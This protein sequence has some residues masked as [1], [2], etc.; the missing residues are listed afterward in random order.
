[1]D[2]TM[3]TDLA[4]F[5]TLVALSNAVDDHGLESPSLRVIARYAHCSASSLLNW[6]GDKGQLHRRTLIALG[7]TWRFTLMAELLP[8]DE[9]GQVYARLRLA[10]AEIARTDPLV[11]AVVDDLI[12]VERRII[13]DTLR[14]SHR[15]QTI[16]PRIITVLHALL[17]QLWDTRSHP[18]AA[19]SRTLLAEVV[20]ALIGSPRS[21]RAA[22]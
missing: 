22:G 19:A 15:L 7:V 18:D 2:F 13:E 8:A 3:A 17:V 12:L 21:E 4:A 14:R 16:D 11:A 9:Q 6:F 20:D 10:Y 1:M 5:D